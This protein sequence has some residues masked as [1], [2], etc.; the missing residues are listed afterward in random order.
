MVS[1]S[2]VICFWIFA[3]SWSKNGFGKLQS[4]GLKLESKNDRELEA[5]VS[6]VES[7]SPVAENPESSWLKSGSLAFTSLKA[8]DEE[9]LNIS[10]KLRSI[11][12]N[13]LSREHSLRCCST[14]G[15]LLKAV[16]HAT[17]MKWYF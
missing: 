13:L 9:F 14:S 8:P 11:F 12:R 7:E 1:G 2:E 15:W 17:Q 10:V 3:A 4:F 6:K 5:E 16:V